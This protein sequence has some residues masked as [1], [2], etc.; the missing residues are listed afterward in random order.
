MA[1]EDTQFELGDTLGE[2]AFG[3]VFECFD[4]SDND[5]KVCCLVRYY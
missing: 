4:K 5:K 3:K 1:T 2:G